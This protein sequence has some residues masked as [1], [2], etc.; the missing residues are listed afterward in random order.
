[1]KLGLYE[2]IV[3]DAAVIADAFFDLSGGRWPLILFCETIKEHLAADNVLG[4]AIVIQKLYE[5]AE[6]PFSW[7][8]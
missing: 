6:Q 7:V 1:M 8:D 5:T 4:A 2:K 3:S